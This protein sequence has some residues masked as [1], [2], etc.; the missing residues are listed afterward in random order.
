VHYPEQ[1]TPAPYGDAG[2]AA[3]AEIYRTYERF[4][5][6]VA[7]GVLRDAGEARECVHEVLLRLLRTPERFDSRRGTLKSFLTVSVRNEALSRVRRKTR[8]AARSQ[9]FEAETIH[10][11][12]SIASARRSDVSS[13]LRILA[14]DQRNVILL[15]YYGRYTH[16]EIADRL[17]QPLGTVKS[18]LSTALRRLRTVLVDNDE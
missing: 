18:R 12:D 17:K 7:S 1:Q 16:E 2:A 8:E 4:F 13:A 15:A 6:S 5:V 10:E 14:P 3:L 9:M 11:D